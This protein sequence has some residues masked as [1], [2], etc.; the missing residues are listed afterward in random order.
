MASQRLYPGLRAELGMD[1]EYLVLGNLIVAENETEAGFIEELAQEQ[2]AAGVPVKIVSAQRC[3]EL[4]HLLEGR[5][6][7]G[8]Y[9]PTER[10]SIRSRSR[11]HTRAPQRSW[12]RKS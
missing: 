8:M 10:R 12:A 3:R 1:V 4:N 11:R 6:L 9:C 7:S 2:A 5:I